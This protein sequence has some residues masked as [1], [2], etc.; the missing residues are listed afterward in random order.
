MVEKLQGKHCWEMGLA[1]L[2]VGEHEKAREMFLTGIRYR[3]LN[4]VMRLY[5]A[6]TF[7]PPSLVAL[8]KRAKH[9]V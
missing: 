4:W 9:A 2:D 6:L 3:P 5:L 7:L 1:C 8:G